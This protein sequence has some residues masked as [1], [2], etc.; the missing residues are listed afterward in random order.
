MAQRIVRVE[1][2]VKDNCGWPVLVRIQYIKDGKLLHDAVFARKG[3]NE[4]F[5]AEKRIVNYIP[6]KRWQMML[7]K[8]AAVMFKKKPKQAIQQNLPFKK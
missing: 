8:A 1:D 6:P 2:V 3:K 5:L 4:V 7:T